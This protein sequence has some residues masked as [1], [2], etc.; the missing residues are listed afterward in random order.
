MSSTYRQCSKCGTAL[1]IGSTFCPNCGTPYSE[2]L[3]P[4]QYA[5]S[6]SS[7]PPT[8]Y[9][10]PSPPLLPTQLAGSSPA[11]PPTQ[12]ASPTTDPY[13]GSPYSASNPTI[14]PYSS[15]PYG[16]PASDPYSSSPYA[17]PLA[18]PYSSSPYGTETAPPPPKTPAPGKRPPIA[19]MVGAVILLLVLAGGGIFFFASSKK[20]PTTPTV[21][22][23]SL[24]VTAEASQALFFDDFANNNKGWTVGQTATSSQTISNNT[25]I[26][27]TS[28]QKAFPTEPLPTQ[29]PFSDFKLVISFTMQQGDKNDYL[30]IAMRSTSDTT[31]DY[32]VHLWG[33]GSYSIGKSYLDSSGNAQYKVFVETTTASFNP[34]GK[35]NTVTIIMVGSTLVLMN[36]NTVVKTVNDSSYATGQIILFLSHGDSSSGTKVAISTIAVYPPPS[37]LPS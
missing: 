28:D 13:G 36:G 24:T 23:A 29:Q 31:R 7:I 18:N 37:Q 35:P 21:N 33:D 11:I 3:A 12:Y 9:A 26:L 17:P 32:E 27:E 30:A 2:P 25:L 34:T 19:V 22:P 10:S 20:T 14:D 5:G 8:E 6:S 4:T 1:P 15:S 16:T